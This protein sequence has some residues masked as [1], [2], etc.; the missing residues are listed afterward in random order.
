MRYL[1]PPQPS[2]SDARRNDELHPSQGLVL[3]LGPRRPSDVEAKMAHWG[4]VGVAIVVAGLVEC[5]AL[6]SHTISLFRL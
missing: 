6:G 4:M 2:S 1:H 3:V 5:V